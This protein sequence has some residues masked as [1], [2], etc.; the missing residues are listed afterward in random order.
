[1]G[2]INGLKRENIRK[3]LQNRRKPIPTKSCG[4]LSARKAAE[5]PI[6]ITPEGGCIL[7]KTVRCISISVRILQADS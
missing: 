4:V 7:R 3:R 6:I 1:M 2:E 5:S